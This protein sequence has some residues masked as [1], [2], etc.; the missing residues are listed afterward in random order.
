MLY[1]VQNIKKV[2]QKRFYLDY[3]FV[4][5]IINRCVLRGVLMMEQFTSS[6]VG[7]FQKFYADGKVKKFP[8][9]TFLCH[10]PKCEFTHFAHW[11]QSQ[12]EQ[13]S[14]AHKFVLLPI[15]SFHMTVYEGVCDQV[16]RK[17]NWVDSLSLDVSLYKVHEYFLS[18]TDLLPKTNVISMKVDRVS[19]S[20][21]MG[22]LFKLIPADEK[23]TLFLQKFRKIMNDELG[24]Q[25][26]VKDNYEFHL[27]LSYILIALTDQEYSI[28]EQLTNRINEEIKKRDFI[29]RLGAVEFCVFEDM[30]HFSTIKKIEE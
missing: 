12:T 18:K 11:V 3:F 26:I 25:N 20:Q 5:D 10:L 9:N 30:F 14:F 23:T 21:D 17:D 6:V 28:V 4:Y 22:Y 29:I 27:S 8:G 13:F 15:S 2:K 16:R 7:E 19:I 24:M 1:L